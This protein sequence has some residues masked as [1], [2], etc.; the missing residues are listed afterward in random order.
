MYINNRF[1]R[2]ERTPRLQISA[3][4]GISEAFTHQEVLQLGLKEKVGSRNTEIRKTVF[5][6]RVNDIAKAQTHGMCGVRSICVW[7]H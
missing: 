5:S 6:G 1:Q 2:R 3:S 7:N 4:L